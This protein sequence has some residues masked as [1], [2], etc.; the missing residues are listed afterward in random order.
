MHT[1]TEY[2]KTISKEIAAAKNNSQFK[3][4]ADHRLIL[5]ANRLEKAITQHLHSIDNF[6]QRDTFYFDTLSK[7]IAVCNTLFAVTNDINPNAQ[8]ILDLLTEI[9]RVVP[10]KIRPNLKL[11]NAFVLLQ[12]PLV[13]ASQEKHLAQFNKFQVDPE[14]ITIASIPFEQFEEKERHIYWGNYIWL[15]SYKTKLDRLD[16][17]HADCESPSD[18]LVSLLINVDFNHH[19]FF[20]YCKNAI[21]KRLAAKSGR[22]EKLKELAK[23]KKLVLQDATTNSIPF[24][25][26]EQ[27]IVSKILNWINAEKKFIMVHE[28]EHPFAKLSFQL[29]KYTMAFFFKL[30]HEQQVFGEISFKILSEQ[31]SSTCSARGED[32]PAKSIIA[33]A[34]PKDRKALEEIEELLNKMLQYVRQFI[35]NQ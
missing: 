2:L 1:E 20:V 5:E 14:L 33:K 16:W 9:K 13:V 35:V 26:N 3:K 8:V 19:R 6:I 24:I 7:L 15:K 22:Q 10:S 31:I 12:I 21:I 30:L 29:Y 4:T 18:A 28:M 23:C 34:Y 11:P 17:I 27:P 25:Y 32:V